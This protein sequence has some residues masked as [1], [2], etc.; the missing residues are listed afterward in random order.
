MGGDRNGVSTLLRRA[1]A[2]GDRI[3]HRHSL[4]AVFGTLVLAMA[5]ACDP[6]SHIGKKRAADAILASPSFKAPKVA[7]VPRIL[8][9]QVGSAIPGSVA[10]TASHAGELFNLDQIATLDAAVAVLQ[11]RGRVQVEDFMNPVQQPMSPPVMQPEPLPPPPVADSASTRDSSQGDAAAQRDSAVRLAAALPPAPAPVIE[12]WVHTLRI[13]PRPQL[14]TDL[15]SA[16]DD[17][18]AESTPTPANPSFS[19]LGRTPGW[20]LAIGTREL[21]KILDIRGAKDDGVQAEEGEAVVDFLWRWRATP[22][23]DAFDAQA[24]EFQSL[25]ES[26]RRAAGASGLRMDTAQPQWSRATL[27][28]TP[29]GWEVKAVDWKYG[30]GRT[31]EQK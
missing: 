9:V 7:H 31:L 12:D 13:T 29:S 8:S 1:R 11:A 2:A 22:A 3:R 20:K 27:R 26:V 15:L 21:V 10:A 23:G 16:D 17:D 18:D 4:F 25:P 5:A 28:H 19:H 24:P 30:E 6:A 14:E